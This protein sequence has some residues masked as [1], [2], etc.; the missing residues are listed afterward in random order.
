MFISCVCCV[1]SGLC[2]ELIT[3]AEES[4]RAHTHGANLVRACVRM[5]VCV[6][7]LACA[8]MRACARDLETSKQGG[9]GLI[10]AVAPQKRNPMEK[11]E[12]GS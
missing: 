5:C 2:D 12:G 1:G 3:C 10:L 11:G 9:L 6:Y 4:Y 8:C 7:V